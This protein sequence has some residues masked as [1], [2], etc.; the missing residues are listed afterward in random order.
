MLSIP[1]VGSKRDTSVDVACD[2]PL[3]FIPSAVLFDIVI[4][5]DLEVSSD[6]A[7]L[8]A[9]AD[10]VSCFPPPLFFLPQSPTL[11]KPFPSQF[12]PSSH[13]LSSVYRN[14]PAGFYFHDARIAGCAPPNLVVAFI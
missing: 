9:M 7:R 5:L 6:S 12:A 10:R 4:L 11:P 1:V 13:S 8:L 2:A 14:V 3:A